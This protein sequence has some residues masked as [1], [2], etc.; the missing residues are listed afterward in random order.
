MGRGA[1]KSQRELIDTL[2]HEELHHRWFVRGV[3]GHHKN[4]VLDQKFPNVVNSYM[5]MR[6]L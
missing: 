6:G 4:P 1:F 3:Y 5:R 2:V